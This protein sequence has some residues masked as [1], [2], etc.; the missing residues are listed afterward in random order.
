MDAMNLGGDRHKALTGEVFNSSDEAIRK[1]L[2][3]LK[4]EKAELQ[5]KTEKVDAQIELLNKILGSVVT[6]RKG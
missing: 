2:E 5:M 4:K 6:T 1:E 3:L